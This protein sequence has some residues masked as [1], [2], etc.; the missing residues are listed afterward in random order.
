MHAADDVGQRGD[1]AADEEGVHDEPGQFA[2]GEFAALHEVAAVPH[3][4]DD[5]AEDD[6]DDEGDERGAM[7]GA[8]E[9]D[10]EIDT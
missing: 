7:A 1:A 10:F 2:M 4:E 6:E 9:D 8:A 3:D 5:G